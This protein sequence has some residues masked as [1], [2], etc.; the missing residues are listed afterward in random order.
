MGSRGDGTNWEK[1]WKEEEEGEWEEHDE[2]RVRD[3]ANTIN[4]AHL[5]PSS[6]SITRTPTVLDAKRLTNT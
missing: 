5:L 2:S 3:G 6:S 1:L 4:S